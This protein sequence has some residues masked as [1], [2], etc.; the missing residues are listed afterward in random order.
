M[1][2]GNRSISLQSLCCVW[3][4]SKKKVVFKLLQI[5]LQF[6][7]FLS[8]E[9]RNKRSKKHSVL[10]DHGFGF[11]FSFHNE[12][13]NEKISLLSA[14]GWILQ[15]FL[16]LVLPL[17]NQQENKHSLTTENAVQKPAMQFRYFWCSL[18]TNCVREPLATFSEQL[19]AVLLA[20]AAFCSPIRW[21]YLLARSRK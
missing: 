13:K 20:S 4:L 15:W 9:A 19:P 10:M 14:R 18:K 11:R 17:Q 7:T 1:P 2:Y 12:D 8:N 3:L 21:V 16:T 5:V 6:F